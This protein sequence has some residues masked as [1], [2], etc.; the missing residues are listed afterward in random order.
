MPVRERP[1]G[2]TVLA[3]LY[4]IEGLSFLLFPLIGTMV[5]SFILG[6]VAPTVMCW[7][8]FAIPALICILVAVGLLGGKGWARTLALLFAIIGLLSVPLG[9]IMSIIILVYLFKPEVKAYFGK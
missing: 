7:I 3:V 8:I 5:L 6:D 9:T 1:A 4:I 2:V